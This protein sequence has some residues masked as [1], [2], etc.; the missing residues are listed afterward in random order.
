MSAVVSTPGGENDPLCGLKYDNYIL[1]PRE[2]PVNTAPPADLHIGLRT[3]FG[4]LARPRV[5]GVEESCRLSSLPVGPSQ[6]WTE[7]VTRDL[8]V[9]CDNPYVVRWN[10]VQANPGGRRS[11]KLL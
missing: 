2:P 5:S 1:R 6:R 10:F 8:N 9:L 11:A 7:S 4:C 3:R